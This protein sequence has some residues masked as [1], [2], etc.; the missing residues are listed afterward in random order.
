MATPR[1][2]PQRPRLIVDQRDETDRVKILCVAPSSKARG[3]KR[4]E[5]DM[6][7]GMRPSRRRMNTIVQRDIESMGET[8]AEREVVDRGVRK[9]KAWYRAYV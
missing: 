2:R 5:G 1:P 9:G 7:K 3:K 8:T 4:V 6:Y